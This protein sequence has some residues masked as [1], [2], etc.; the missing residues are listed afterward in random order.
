[1]EKMK[2]NPK[3]EKRKR[4]R[5]RR[6]PTDGDTKSGQNSAPSK[7]KK[8]GLGKFFGGKGREKMEKLGKIRKGKT[9]KK[10]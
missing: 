7:T 8:L 4:I 5:P 3:T 10:N 1:M 2:E 9:T 6:V